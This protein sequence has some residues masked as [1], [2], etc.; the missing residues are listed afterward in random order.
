MQE[1]TTIACASALLQSWISRFG[2]PEH[3]T[4]DRGSAF[5][6]GLWC[7]LA[8]L[9]GIQLHYT[10]AYHPQAN[11]MVERCHRTMKAALMTRCSHLNWTDQLPWV[12]LGLRSTPKE[13]LDVSAAEMV[14]GQPLVVPGEFFPQQ[15]SNSD[16]S[17]ELQA[18]RWSA[19]QFAPCHPTRHNQ[20]DTYIP[21]DL[22][23]AKYVFIRQDL[24]K[25][26]LSPPYKG[27]YLV[28]QRGDKAYQIDNGGRPDWISTDRLKPAYTDSPSFDTYTRS[29]RKSIVPNRLGL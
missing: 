4:S 3:I 25:P 14:F 16:H 12:M 27:P 18:A 6:S 2:L 17:A 10:T 9:L 13:G 23:T 28:L 22:L 20:R 26:P 7:A 8:K 21:A 11:G 19:K 29:G 5:I 24:V 15:I 1:E